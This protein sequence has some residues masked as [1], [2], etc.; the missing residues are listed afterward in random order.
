MNAV[1][2]DLSGLRYAAGVDQQAGALAWSE[3][4]GIRRFWIVTS[5]RTQRWVLPKGGIDDGMTPPEAAAQE[6]FEEAGVIAEPKSEGIGTYRVA[7]IRP[8]LIWTVE[9]VLYPMLVRE[10]LPE[11]KESE[12]RQRRLV[13]LD[14]AA[15]LIIEPEIIALIRRELPKLRQD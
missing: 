3:V 13:T 11:W 5:R 10:V 7:K 2:E 1:S 8:P 6:A 4:D 12:Q 14:E 15:D 9:I